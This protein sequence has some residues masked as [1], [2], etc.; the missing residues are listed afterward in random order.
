MWCSIARHPDR[1]HRLPSCGLVG[2]RLGGPRVERPLGTEE[3]LIELSERGGGGE[4][5]KMHE[6]MSL[7]LARQRREEL[8]RE[9]EMGRQ[10]KA[11][12]ATRKRRTGRRSILAWE[13]NRQAQRLL[14]FLRRTLRKAG[15]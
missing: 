7:E 12:R 6:M 2:D 14:K 3:S 8:L 4:P 13:M 9:A 10:A 1:P 15:G 5:R 11:L